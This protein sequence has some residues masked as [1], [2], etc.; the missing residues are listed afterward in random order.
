MNY[1]DSM[2]TLLKSKVKW[3]GN[4]EIDNKLRDKYRKVIKDEDYFDFISEAGNGGFFLDSS[5]QFYSFITEEN[6]QN[7]DLVNDIFLKAYG[8]YSMGIR[9]I[10]QDV[11]GNQFVYDVY[12]QKFLLF[13]IETAYKEEL[14]KNFKGF[15]ET[16]VTDIEYYSGR[17]FILNWNNEIQ[18]NQRLCP[19]KPFVIGGEYNNDNFYAST[20]PKYLEFFADIARQIHELPD[21]TPIK[22]KIIE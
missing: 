20:F 9:T 15:V 2:E 4:S 11:F 21:G 12:T 3:A 7:I 22:L 14:A 5:L 8:K 13:N 19:K 1:K 16:L 6:Y 17:S 18:F 10:G